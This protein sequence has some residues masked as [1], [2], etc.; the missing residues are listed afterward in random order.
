MTT[1][2]LTKNS[3]SSRRRF[4]VV[5]TTR[6]DLVLGTY[7]P[8]PE[9]TGL[10][11]PQA[12]LTRTP[13]TGNADMIVTTAGAVIE[14]LDIHGRLL[15]RAANVQVR[16]CIIRGR[17]STTNE[18]CVDTTHVDCVNANI[19]DCILRP[20][21]P[22]IWTN[23]VLGRNFVLFRCDVSNMVDG[24][25]VYNTLSPG[26]ALNVRI[27]QNWFHDFTYFTPDSTH[28]TDNQT[29]NDGI[30]LQG[31]LGAI[32]RGNY[33]DCH[34]G[35]GGS[36]Q[37]DNTAS[38]SPSGFNNPAFAAILMND[39]VG[40]TGNHII[41]DNHINGAYI[42]F[43]T[44]DTTLTGNLGRMWRNTFSRDSVLTGSVPQTIL[45]RSTANQQ[46][47]C[48]ENTSNQNIFTDGTPVL[49]RRTSP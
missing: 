15:I 47:D 22:S 28:A 44:G 23:G 34:Y 41:E 40:T 13:A 10:T 27:D 38:P 48:G 26:T 33:I 2:R 17:N 9:T 19:R 36:H 3:F 42:P 18:G 7:R 39:N 20:I 11:V 8:G 46:C 5:S 25:G 12:S 29:H 43:N 37:P 24:C 1:R 31:G 14:N 4:E 49:V 21:F 35:N 16:N 45:L 32:I 30:Q 6:D